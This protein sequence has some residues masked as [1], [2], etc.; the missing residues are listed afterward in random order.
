MILFEL[1]MNFLSFVYF[2]ELF[3]IEQELTVPVYT[4]D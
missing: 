3:R 2:L 4:L 1:D